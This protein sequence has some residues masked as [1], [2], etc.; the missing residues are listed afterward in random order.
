MSVSLD[1]H[2]L[3]GLRWIVLRG[4]DLDAFRALGEHMR[5]EMA[6][7]TAAW[8]LPARLHGHVSGPPG[9]DRFQAARQA[10]VLHFPQAWAELAALAEGAAVPFDDLVLLNFRGDLGPITGGIGCS[11]LA[12]RRGRSVI[13]HNEDGAAENVGQCALLTLALDGLPTVTAF[14]YPG[15]LPANA[16][17]VTADGLVWTIDHLPVA[18]PGAGAG[19]HFVGRGVQ[20]SATTVDQVVDHLRAHPSAGGFAYTVGDRSGRIVNVEAAAGH[21]AAVEAGPGSCPLMWHTNHG[22]YI[23]GCEASPTGTSAVR[24]EIL[25]ALAVPDEDPEPTWFLDVLAGA[26]LPEGVRA[27]PAHG[28]A[29]TTLCTFIADLTAGQA[30]IAA[31]D[32]Q[33]VAI[34]LPD[35]AEGNPHGQREFAGSGDGGYATRIG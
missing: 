9:S 5:A 16:F 28:G 14:W 4:P 15:F 1:E 21:H 3:G 18:E 26:P 8:P 12:W 25:E 6:E 34:A 30:V 13:A 7:L 11:D 10:S 32:E 33:P 23:P 27:D 19:R 24:G 20:R 17:T 2:Q 35:L 31:R 22:R 29:A